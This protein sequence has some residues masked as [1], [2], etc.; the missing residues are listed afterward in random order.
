MENFHP[1]TSD[2][3]SARLPSGYF[4]NTRATFHSRKFSQLHPPILTF[5]FSPLFDR[6]KK[7]PKSS[8]NLWLFAWFRV[9]LS[10]LMHKTRSSVQLNNYPRTS[11]SSIALL[12]L[13]SLVDVSSPPKL[14]MGLRRLT[15]FYDYAVV[16][17]Q[18]PASPEA[19][20]RLLRWESPSIQ[21]TQFMGNST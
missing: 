18:I 14:Q 7:V 11:T 1:Y 12:R 10:A 9:P 3:I 15:L 2:R 13:Q 19:T 6:L 8:A 16:M 17:V 4:S 5:S 20:K 21:E